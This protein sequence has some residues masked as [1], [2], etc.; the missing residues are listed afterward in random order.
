MKDRE[1]SKGI[2]VNP[3]RMGGEPTIKGTRITARM[4]ANLQAGDEPVDPY[5]ILEGYPALTYAD[6]VNAKLWAGR[7]HTA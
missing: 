4:V 2:V 5:A 7:L 1:I 3:G 6:L